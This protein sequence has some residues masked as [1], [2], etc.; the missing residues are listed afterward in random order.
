MAK[1]NFPTTTT[2]TIPCNPSY[3][4]V[5]LKKDQTF[6]LP[7]GGKIISV[8]N[9]DNVE[10][11]CIDLAILEELKCYEIVITAV[12]DDN[13][14]PYSNDRWSDFIIEGFL[15]KGVFYPV[16]ELNCSRE[17]IFYYDQ[18]INYINNPNSPLN[19]IIINPSQ[20][21][22]VDDNANQG[23]QSALCFQT[24]PSLAND[25]YIKTRTNLDEGGTT[26]NAYYKAV[27]FRTISGTGDWGKFNKLGGCSCS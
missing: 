21:I 1:I 8:T 23:A 11:D 7:P 2:T 5:T 12:D 27:P 6:I 14:T 20:E 16:P 3:I 19:G 9:K 17:G 25:M 15:I 26:A 18:I 24:L 4:S 10:S 13:S 22:V